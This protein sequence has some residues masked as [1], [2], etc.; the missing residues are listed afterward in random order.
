MKNL[1]FTCVFFL[2]L[3]ISGF[4]QNDQ[5][6]EKANTIVKEMNDEIMSVDKS[7]ALSKDQ[8]AQLKTIHVNRLKELRKAKKEGADKSGNKEINKKYYQKIF[9]EV[10]TKDQI[11]ARKTAKENSKE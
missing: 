9:K 5:I 8:E 1:F 10:L 6:V 11:K 3:S 4:A 7:L 2:G